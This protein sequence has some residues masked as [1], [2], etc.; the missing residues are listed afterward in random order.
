MGLTSEF[1]FL[2]RN[3]QTRVEFLI[4]E[5]DILGIS[6]LLSAIFKKNKYLSSHNRY[7]E[8]VWRP[9]GGCP[10]ANL[11][12]IYAQVVLAITMSHGLKHNSFLQ[13]GISS[14]EKFTF[15]ID[16]LISV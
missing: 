12:L 16:L 10:L 9:R 2:M 14:D 7:Y 4:W 6:F 11:F 3:F 5:N 1:V 13:W 15:P 8:L